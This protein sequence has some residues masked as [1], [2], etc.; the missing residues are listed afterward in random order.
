MRN[1]LTIP[2]D[3]IKRS[4]QIQD[5]RMQLIGD[6]LTK[7]WSWGIASPV[8]PPQFRSKSL[9]YKYTPPGMYLF[10]FKIIWKSQAHP[11]SQ[12]LI[13]KSHTWLWRFYLLRIFRN[14]CLSLLRSKH[15]VIAEGGCS[16]VMLNLYTSYAKLS[17]VVYSLNLEKN[18]PGKFTSS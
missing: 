7:V 16:H 4:R 14:E 15:A 2:W 12:D 18:K 13:V 17:D 8:G 6:I 11:W 5:C 1:S 10:Y 9:V 3:G